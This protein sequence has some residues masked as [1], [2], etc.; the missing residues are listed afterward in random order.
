MLE[1]SNRALSDILRRRA[2]WP[3]TEDIVDLVAA[4]FR[5]PPF[6]GPRSIYWGDVSGSGRH[7]RRFL[8]SRH[9][10]AEQAAGITR[11]VASFLRFCA[12]AASRNSSRA[13]LGPRNL[14]RPSLRMR[15]R[16]ANS[17]SIFF[18]R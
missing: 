18:R 17:I 7:R 9:A 8:W 6:S 16:W 13:P 11:S 10:A 14:R 1:A 15:L 5:A 12:V 4:L 2:T 3:L